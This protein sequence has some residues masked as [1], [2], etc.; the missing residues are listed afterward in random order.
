MYLEQK[1]TVFAQVK[2]RVGIRRTNDD[3]YEAQITSCLLH[4]KN[5]KYSI[6]QQ[7]NYITFKVLVFYENLNDVGTSD[8]VL[9]TSEI[10]IVKCV[11][12]LRLFV[13]NL[14]K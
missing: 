1:T 5:N 10:R 11:F 13:S 4:T 14:I 3:K 7:Y 6:T 12:D 8:L 2:I 9:Y